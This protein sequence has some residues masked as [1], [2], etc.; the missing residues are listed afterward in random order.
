MQ[1]CITMRISSIKPNK[2][3]IQEHMENM[4]QIKALSNELVS[5]FYSDLNLNH[6]V[7]RHKYFETAFNNS[8]RLCGLMV[9]VPGYRSRDPGSIPGAT[10]FSEKQW[11]WNGVHSA[12]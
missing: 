7:S 4:K 10:R 3:F 5:S 6:I 8:S 2:P 11:V 9:R 1:F 12:S